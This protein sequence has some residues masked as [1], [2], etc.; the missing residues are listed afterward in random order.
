MAEVVYRLVNTMQES[1][2]GVL[3]KPEASVSIISPHCSHGVWSVMY[4]GGLALSLPAARSK[5]FD[6]SFVL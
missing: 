5:C 2:S 4:L 3:D 6:C 1:I